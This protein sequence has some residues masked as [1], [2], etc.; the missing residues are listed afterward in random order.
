MSQKRQ[1]DDDDD[2]KPSSVPG[3]K[4]QKLR[5]VIQEVM[6]LHKL[7]NL[8]SGMEPLLRKVVREEVDIAL[9]KHFS[10]KQNCGNQV[11]PSTSKSLQLH[12]RNKLSLP[13]FTGAKI[14]GEESS[15]IEVA[16]VDAFTG[17]IVC[18]GPESSVKVEIVVLEGDF[19]GGDDDWS[20]EEFNSNIVRERGGKRPLLTGESILNLKE[21][22][23]MVGELF[24]TDN[25]SW[26]RSRKFRLG[27][28]VLGDNLDG[29]RVRE[30]K[31]AAFMVKDHRG[32][33]YKKHHP[34]SL[35]DEVWRLEKI[36]KD[37]AFHKRLS[38]EN[39]NTVKDFLTL[40]NLDTPQLKNILGTGM[41][42]KMWEVTVDHART[43]ILDNQ[44]FLYYPATTTEHKTGVVFDVVCQTLGI[45]SEGRFIPMD[46]LSET[47]RV[48]S[49]KLVKLA[50]ENRE[51]VC[52]Y[53]DRSI[54]M[55]GASFP[56]SSAVVGNEYGYVQSS[57]SVSDM[58]PSSMLPLHGF[59]DTMD[60][61]Y[62]QFSSSFDIDAEAMV[63]SFG[64]GDHMP[65]FEPDPFSFGLEADL[66]T[67][68]DG[69]LA[70]SSRS[71]AATTSTSCGKV[72][73]TKWNMLYRVLRWRFSIKRLMA[74]KKSGTSCRLEEI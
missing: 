40:F 22:T 62:D 41:S 43:C 32:E 10:K 44:K 2:N 66:Q 70:M 15:I 52:S 74:S 63:E 45:I 8:F 60:P 27:A 24:F 26:T 16:L 21:G 50:Y 73:Q 59:D 33:L 69:F 31:T 11:H 57:C 7:Q 61:R 51:Q 6:R 56:S 35:G 48:N 67:A 72:A 13:I 9:K 54:M 12:F 42:A 68:V 38:R 1:P 19:E 29:I 39:I 3:E 5:S 28:R 30:A 20:P 46:K 64:N 4:R 14:E 55:D 36:G 25:S 65:F 34:P 53:D 71:S 49:N 18:T 23:C 37:G 47:E 17:E 58:V